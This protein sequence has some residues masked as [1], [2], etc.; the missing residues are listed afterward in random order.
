VQSTD[1]GHIR[2]LIVSQPPIAGVPRHIR[3]L[4]AFL[5]DNRYQLDIAC[6]RS[7]ELWAALAGRPGLTLHPI[8]SARR[9]SPQD[10]ASW[11]RLLFLARRADIIH[12]HSSKAGFL[13]RLAAA[14]TGRRRACIF[15][16]H[17]WSFW[18][19]DGA[20]RGLYV[21]L[22]RLAA[23]WC[24][25]IVAL[26]AFERDSALEQGVGDQEQFRV[27]SNGIDLD[28]FSLP[29]Q[30]VDH[31]VAMVARL[32]PQKNPAL[33]VRAFHRLRAWGSEAQLDLIGDGPLMRPTARLVSQL[34]LE[35]TVRLLG[36]RFD[37][38]EL[39]A[40]AS[41]MLLA[42][43]YEACPLA[44]LEGMAAGLPVVATR[45]GGMSELIDHGRTGF[46]VDPEPTAIAKALDHVLS[47]PDQAHEIGIAARKE[48][49]RR[50]RRERM[51]REIAAL[52]E[53]TAS[54][55]RR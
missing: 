5:D 49:R 31:R 17:G 25:T 7:S 46:V 42:T 38:P 52:Y 12:A 33:A 54:A 50:F 14:V 21:Q 47:H 9:P 27:I 41:C 1:N 19:F 4:V 51:A 53:E 36:T 55:A 8:T 30:P 45:V 35:G 18:A 44:V 32:V 2:V 34:G 16:P 48:A 37:V 29:R 26:S 39:L 13:A 28:R 6:P 20:E 15:T 23:R 11:A 40:E 43:N 22:E 10:L 3:D 24:Q